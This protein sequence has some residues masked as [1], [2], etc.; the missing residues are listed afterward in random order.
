MAPWHQTLPPPQ[1]QAAKNA[2][3]SFFCQLCSK[4][5]ARVNEYEAHLGSYDHSHKQRLKDMKAMVKDSNAVA[6]ARKAEAK[7]DG[8]VSVKIPRVEESN[9]SSQTTSTSGGFKKGGFKKK[10]GPSTT[11]S[12]RV[13]PTS[14]S[15]LLP[16]G[17]VTGS[18]ELASSVGADGR[19][20]LESSDDEMYERYDPRRP[21]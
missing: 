4:G 10:T 2:L 8:I 16:S 12:H 15:H 3:Q 9:T 19:I 1:T 13:K 21:T 20:A 11:A 18:N 6:R 17:R 5:Y 14:P 7:A